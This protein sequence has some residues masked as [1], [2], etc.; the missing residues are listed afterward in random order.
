MTNTNDSRL[1][2]LL[3]ENACYNIEIFC[4]STTKR[5]KFPAFLTDFSDSF[6][7]DYS[8]TSVYGRM[9]PIYSYKN[10]TRTVTLAFDIPNANFS[11][12]EFNSAQIN[13]L[14]QSLYPVYASE[15]KNDKGTSIVSSPPM[16]RIKFGNLVSNFSVTKQSD[17]NDSLQ[18]GLLGF[19]PS[20]DFKPK[21]DSGFFVNNNK[22]YPKLLS[23]NLTLNVVHEHPLGNKFDENGNIVARTSAN[24]SSF[25]HGFSTNIPSV[26]MPRENP[27]NQAVSKVEGDRSQAEE[28][29]ALG[30]T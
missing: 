27:A 15:A 3:S 4:F 9:D 11:E 1:K 25:P 7:V 24:N 6:K 16:F 10:T 29:R 12:S 26:V 2:T 30:A 21:V 17:I 28:D 22:L 14:I 8:N 18:E 23:A 5:I 19:I 20:F 13:V